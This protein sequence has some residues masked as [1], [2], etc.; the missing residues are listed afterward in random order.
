MIFFNCS[1]DG[2]NTPCVAELDTFVQSF[3]FEEIMKIAQRAPRSNYIFQSAKIR[4][5]KPTL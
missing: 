5:L 4:Y 3:H 1:L 2:A